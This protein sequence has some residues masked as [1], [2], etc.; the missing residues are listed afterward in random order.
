MDS[1]R[2]DRGRGERCQYGGATG[3][4]MK[5]ACLW[6]VEGSPCTLLESGSRQLKTG[7]RKRGNYRTRGLRDEGWEEGELVI[8]SLLK[9]DSLEAQR[10]RGYK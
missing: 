1:R 10:R 7:K 5:E 4:D 2:K 6:P 9:T 3:E 8:A